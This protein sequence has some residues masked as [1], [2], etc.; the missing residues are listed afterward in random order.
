[1]KID[2]SNTEMAQ[3]ILIVDDELY[4]RELYEEVIQSA[5]FDVET[6]LDGK[7]GLEKI[8]TGNFDLVLLDVMMPELDGIGVLQKLKNENPK[9]ARMPVIVICT[10]LSHD[11]VINEAKNLGASAYIV[12]ADVVPDQIIEKIKQ[13]LNIAPAA[14]TPAPAA[15]PSQ[16]AAAAPAAPANPAPDTTKTS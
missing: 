9:P 6:A 1:M 4:L 15:A 11:P 3:R 8:R 7:E 5:G 2:Y 10:N 14:N 13:L 16:P 12:K